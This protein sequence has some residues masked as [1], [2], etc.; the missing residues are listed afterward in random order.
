MDHNVRYK[1][2]FAELVKKYGSAGRIPHD[3]VHVI[4]ERLRAAHVIEKYGKPDPAIL[5]DYSI[6]SSII[7]EYCGTDVS[8]IPTK[9]TRRQRW[10]MVEQWCKDNVGTTVTPATLAEVGD[11]SENSC[12]TFIK[13][14]PDLFSQVK[15]GYY[16]VR[17]PEAERNAS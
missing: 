9:R 17:D 16:L 4:G 7:V 2:E 12:R 13:D 15:R 3:E 14:R 10:K 6:P 11:F 5:R 1:Q 8:D